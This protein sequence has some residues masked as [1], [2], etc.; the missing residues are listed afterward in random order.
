[1]PRLEVSTPQQNYAITVERNAI[2]R[3]GDVLPPRCGKLFVVTTEDVWS[4]HGARVRDTLGDR[5]FETLVF[6]GGEPRKRLAHVERLAEQM[7]ELGADR[8]SIVIAF[9]GGI[10]TDLGGFL[11][12]IF[13]RGV[14]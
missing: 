8:S 12:A 14:P 1:M 11:A 2:A 4:L 7:A 9:G 3:L 6:E 10:V 13:M 5:D